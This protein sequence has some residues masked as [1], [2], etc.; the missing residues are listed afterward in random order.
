MWFNV[1][2]MCKWH[3][4]Y[5]AG[6]A[7]LHNAECIEP[8]SF[9]KPY[10]VFNVQP[11]NCR[12]YTVY[13]LYI[14]WPFLNACHTVIDVYVFVLLFQTATG[15]NSQTLEIQLTCVIYISE[16]QICKLCLSVS[17]YCFVVMQF[18]CRIVWVVCT[19]LP[20]N[21]NVQ[22]IWH[23]VCRLDCWLLKQVSCANIFLC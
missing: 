18:K 9:T 8:R 23:K 22:L 21:S 6:S 10:H 5:E 7:V 16:H 3:A 1:G 2:E 17:H 20:H 15:F 12:S 13:S 14:C 4:V 19:A 11:F